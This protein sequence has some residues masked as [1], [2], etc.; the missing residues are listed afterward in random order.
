MNH[1]VERT[2]QR[3]RLARLIVGVAVLG[4][5]AASV[6]AQRGGGA[7]APAAAPQSPQAAA[8]IDLDRVL[9]IDRQRR[10]AMAD[11]DTAEG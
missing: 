3:A 11:G 4:V 9:G 2:L 1:R 8:P 10:L 6:S 7:A 5:M